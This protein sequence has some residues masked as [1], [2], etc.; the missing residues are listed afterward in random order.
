MLDD[1]EAEVSRSTAAL[2]AWAE[3]LPEP[4][5]EAVMSADAASPV[6]FR[7]VPAVRHELSPLR[8]AVTEWAQGFGFDRDTLADLVLAVDEAVTNAIEHGY[9]NQPAGIVR[10]FAGH[11]PVEKAVNVVVADSG[12]WRPPPS[13][14]GVRGRGLS[15]IRAVTDRFDLHHGEHGTVALLSWKLPGEGAGGPAG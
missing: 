6:L 4:V 1:T 11:S 5:C 9:R 10:F 3:Q 7:A 14:P 2:H 13:E 12:S 15:I 8:A